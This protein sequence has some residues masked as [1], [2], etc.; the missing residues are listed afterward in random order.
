[1]DWVTLRLRNQL[2]GIKLQSWFMDLDN[3]YNIKYEALVYLDYAEIG[4]STSSLV[5]LVSNR[6]RGLR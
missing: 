4:L 6:V 1:M 2:S 3:I 5:L